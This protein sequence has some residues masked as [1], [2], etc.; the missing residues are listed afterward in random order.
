MVFPDR[1][2]YV[3]MKCPFM[4]AYMRLL[5]ETCHRR[6]ALATT[7][8]SALVLDPTWSPATVQAGHDDTHVCVESRGYPA[9][10]LVVADVRVVLSSMCAQEKVAGVR[11]A[12]D[13]E[14]QAGSDGALV[15][16]ITLC[17]DVREVFTAE[18]RLSPLQGDCTGCP[19]VASWP[20]LGVVVGVASWRPGRGGAR[21][22][23]PPS[24]R[25]PPTS[26][27][28]RPEASPWTA[29]GRAD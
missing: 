20:D 4:R 27:A 10:L 19:S 9:P 3:N 17:T 7:G 2:K 18:V 6:G 25:S 28:C 12:K 26:S 16:D 14:A 13:Y 29:S 24:T 11:D 21:H 5:V 1:T 23:A 22:R 8:M 15:Y